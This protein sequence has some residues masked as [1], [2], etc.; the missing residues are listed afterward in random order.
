MYFLNIQIDPASGGFTFSA[1]LNNRE[2]K[3]IFN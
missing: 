1:Q 2:H 3:G